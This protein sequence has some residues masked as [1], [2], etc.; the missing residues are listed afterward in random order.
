MIWI[1]TVKS[2]Y[3]PQVLPFLSN[4]SIVENN[5]YKK[6]K[7]PVQIYN[8]YSSNDFEEGFDDCL[9]EKQSIAIIPVTIGSKNFLNVYSIDIFDEKFHNFFLHHQKKIPQFIQSLEPCPDNFLNKYHSETILAAGSENGEIYLWQIEDKESIEYQSIYNRFNYKND[10]KFNESVIKFQQNRKMT[11]SVVNSLSWNKINKNLIISC[12]A[13]GLISLVDINT[14]N[15]CKL[16]KWKKSEPLSLKCNPFNDFEYITLMKDSSY[17]LADYRY[18]KNVA[19]IK[20]NKKLAAVDWIFSENFLYEIETNGFISIFDKRYMDK[21]DYPN[22][23]SRILAISDEIVHTDI[24]KNYKKIALLNK[25]GSIVTWEITDHIKFWNKKVLNVK[26]NAKKIA[27]SPF[28]S[29]NMLI[30]MNEDF[31]IS[32]LF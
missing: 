4:L 17:I 28:K 2:I 3:I 9:D 32:L 16:F 22:P 13:N 24:S 23:L 25:K 6:P 27:C 19:L 18:K 21:L 15:C 14:E 20:S 31:S 30:A 11:N 29:N 8:E 26:K 12:L 10:L 7:N 5:Y 1:S